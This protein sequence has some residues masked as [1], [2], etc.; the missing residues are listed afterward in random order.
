[1]VASFNL[2][3]HIS[4]NYSSEIDSKN[5]RP[6]KSNRRDTPTDGSSSLLLLDG[7]STETLSVDEASMLTSSMKP[8]I[9][10]HEHE[11]LTSRYRAMGTS[12]MSCCERYGLSINPSSIFSR[13]MQSFQHHHHHR[14]R[15]HRL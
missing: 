11:R 7:V 3:W 12:F 6:V 9:V 10:H 15:H 8:R 1:M 13:M 4:A 14:R 2:H 5:C